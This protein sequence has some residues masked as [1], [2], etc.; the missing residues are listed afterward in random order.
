MLSAGEV[1]GRCGISGKQSASDPV[2]KY[3]W[4]S[5]ELRLLA[6]KDRHSSRETGTHYDLSLAIL[7]IAQKVRLCL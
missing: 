4:F 1:V 5:A 3:D 6:D 2:L 7:A